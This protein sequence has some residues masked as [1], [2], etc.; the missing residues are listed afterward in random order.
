MSENKIKLLAE[1][2]K[3]L[4]KIDIYSIKIESKTDRIFDSKIGGIPYWSPDKNYPINS[5]GN[6][7]YLLAQ[8][9][10]EEEKVDFP[11]PKSGILQFF[12][13]D[14][15][16]GMNSDQ[17]KQDNFRVVYHETIDYNMTKEAVEKLGAI[18]T[19]KAESFPI[20]DEYKI[21]LHKGTDYVG[22]CDINFHKFFALAYKE[23]YNKNLAEDERYDDVLG[24]DEI[25]DLENEL[26]TNESR[27]KMLGYSF[28]TQEDPRNNE[29]YKDYDTLLLQIDSEGKYVLWGDVGVGNFFISKKALEEKDFSNVLYNWDCS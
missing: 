17:T 24:N 7:L 3:R 28:F 11:L 5:S 13:D 20:N 16:F 25:Y 12:I 18:D 8:V 9:N 21:S 29:K 19:K 14:D 26:E 10:F 15:L 23:V 1:V 22:L 4:S 6:K 27:H 2:I